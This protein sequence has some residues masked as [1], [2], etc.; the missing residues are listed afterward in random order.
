MMNQ[1]RS[2]VAVT[3]TAIV[4]V[5]LILVI[6]G[7]SEKKKG[8]HVTDI[9]PK[10]GP[11]HGGG[12]VTIRGSGF[13]SSGA[14]QVKVYFGQR[15]AKVLAFEGDSKLV[16]EPPAGKKGQTVDVLLVFDDGSPFTYPEAYTYIDP[17]EGFGVDE[18]TAGERK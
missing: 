3:V 10:T 7:C 11:V 17:N 1:P 8:L 12:Q 15:T 13:Q 2:V 4:T 6:G 9:D 18:L 14:T 16:V 5:M